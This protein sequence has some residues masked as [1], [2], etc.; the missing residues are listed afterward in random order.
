MEAIREIQGDFKSTEHIYQRR[1]HPSGV[2]FVTH[3]LASHHG[4]IFGTEDVEVQCVCCVANLRSG[5]TLSTTLQRFQNAV[6]AVLKFVDKDLK[7]R[8]YNHTVQRLNCIVKF[9]AVDL[10]DIRV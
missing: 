3:T 10:S 8:T 7:G 1:K 5:D 9:A 2:A 4:R 6:F